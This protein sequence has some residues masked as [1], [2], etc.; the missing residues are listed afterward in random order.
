M[1]AGRQ[2][3]APSPQRTTQKLWQVPCN[4][5]QAPL[6]FRH[7][8]EEIAHEKNPVG[9]CGAR[10]PADGRGQRSGSPQGSRFGFYVG[11][12]GG[13]NCCKTTTTATTWA[14]RSAARSATTSSAAR[15][16]GRHLPQQH[17]QRHRAVPNGAAF[18][19]GQINQVSVLA[20]LL[21][22]LRR[23]PPSRRSSAPAP[24]SPS[25]TRR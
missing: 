15:R 24:A 16:V 6:R 25:S 4:A 5:A 12:E 22:D 23:V 13:L 21:Y 1:K 20:N 3:V 18:V 8:C 9:R 17:G 19:T 10:R 7:H 14:T 11:G 2:T